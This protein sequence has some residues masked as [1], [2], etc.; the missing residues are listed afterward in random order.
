VF[1]HLKKDLD[2]LL[3]QETS[4]LKYVIREKDAEIVRLKA[5]NE[6]LQRLMVDLDSPHNTYNVRVKKNVYSEDVFNQKRFEHDKLES[7]EMGIF[8]NKDSCKEVFESGAKQYEDEY[9]VSRRCSNIVADI[10]R[11]L[12]LS[13][14]ISKKKKSVSGFSQRST[15]VIVESER[16]FFKIAKMYLGDDGFSKLIDTLNKYNEGTTTYHELL[17]TVTMITRGMK[18]SEEMIDLVS[19]LVKG[20]WTENLL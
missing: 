12:F 14:G 7:R 9:K 18:N 10:D 2:L 17:H 6:A 20:K 13:P 4:K 11:S 19:Q 3:E 8:V 16:D 15:E 5:E 1:K